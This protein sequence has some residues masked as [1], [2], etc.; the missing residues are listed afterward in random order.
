MSV[1]NGQETWQWIR[2]YSKFLIVRTPNY[3][4]WE[5]E[6]DE[7]CC[8]DAGFAYDPYRLLETSRLT[9]AA[10]ERLFILDPSV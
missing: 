5:V 10:A 7:F 2:E 8:E 1:M 3:I 9:A 6:N 4:K